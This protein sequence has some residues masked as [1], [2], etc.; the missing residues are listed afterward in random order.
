VKVKVGYFQLDNLR[1]ELYKLPNLHLIAFAS[2]CCQRAY[3][4]A[5]IH[6]RQIKEDGWKGENIW[7]IAMNKIWDFLAGE[8]LDGNLIKELLYSEENEKYPHD[9]ESKNSHEFVLMVQMIDN[10]LELCQGYTLEISYKTMIEIVLVV[11]EQIHENLFDYI[12]CLLD[13]SMDD[14]NDLS[15]E[16]LLE[17]IGNHPLTIKEMQKENEDLHKLQE[18]SNLTPELLQWLRISSCNGDKSFLNLG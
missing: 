3:P 10:T 16:E 12:A 14:V 18:A 11:V 15:H 9:Y 4:H 13:E 2:A 17:E 5:E 6:L 7:E 8:S 1:N